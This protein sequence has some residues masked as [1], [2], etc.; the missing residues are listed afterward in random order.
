MI[1]KMKMK[2]KIKLLTLLCFSMLNLTAVV[3]AEE[4]ITIGITSQ[5]VAKYFN[6]TLSKLTEKA[7]KKRI[8]EF[9]FPQSSSGENLALKNFGISKLEVSKGDIDCSSPSNCTLLLDV[10]KLEMEA[11]AFK[12]KGSE[13]NNI[14]L[15]LKPID[16]SKDILH[17]KLPFKMKSSTTKKG[18]E[19]SLE[20]DPSSEIQF[21]NCEVVSDSKLFTSKITPELLPKIAAYFKTEGVDMLNHLLQK[22][23]PLV[24]QK[25]NR[26]KSFKLPTVP[27]VEDEAKRPTLALQTL[28]KQVQMGHPM[29]QL[30]VFADSADSCQQASAALEKKSAISPKANYDL[31][32][33]LHSKAISEVLARLYQQKFFQCQSNMEANYL[34]MSQSCNVDVKAAATPKVQFENGNIVVEFPCINVDVT[35]TSYF[36]CNINKK[37]TAIIT[38]DPTICPDPEGTSNRLCLNPKVSMQVINEKAN[39]GWFGGYVSSSLTAIFD[40]LLS[41]LSEQASE[42]LAKEKIIP[43]LPMVK[44]PYKLHTQKIASGNDTLDFLITSEF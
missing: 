25:I 35:A 41:M 22:N 17:L 1:L 10:K 3:S 2:M 43:A 14:H 6:K 39:Q 32:V 18:V 42:A 12:Y 24:L 37:V 5:G 26:S 13:E 34:G 8:S 11:G 33:K 21:E 20:I 28:L 30:G 38:L 44:D 31:A 29:I 23:A 9:E 15:G 36:S 27:A 16:P 7:Q 40:Y 19:H 4:L